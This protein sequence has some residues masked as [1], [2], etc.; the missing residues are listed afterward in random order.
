[1]VNATCPQWQL[2]SYEA[3]VVVESDMVREADYGRVSKISYRAECQSQICGKIGLLRL[4]LSW[5]I[6]PPSDYIDAND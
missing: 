5:C 6:W 4:F 3:S 1:M 2:P